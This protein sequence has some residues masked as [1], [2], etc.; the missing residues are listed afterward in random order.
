MKKKLPQIEIV[1]KSNEVTKVWCAWG[2]VIRLILLDLMA[3]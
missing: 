1:N 2:Q 3:G